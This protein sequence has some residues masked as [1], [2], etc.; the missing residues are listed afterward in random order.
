M[1]SDLGH[2]SNIN[3][4]RVDITQGWGDSPLTH[5]GIEEAEKLSGFLKDK[6]ISIIYSSDLGR[7]VQTSEIINQKLNLK[8]IKSPGL[9]EQNFGKFNNT[10]IIKEEFDASDHSKVPPDGESFLK[11]KQRV[12]TY[13]K[14]KLPRNKDKVLIVTHDGC[15]RAILSDALN[16]DLDSPECATT[17]LTIGLFD[18]KNKDIKFIDKF[19][20]S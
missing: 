9:R 10:S 11:M 1:I 14:T 5:Q 19:N 2:V 4:T 13:I 7:C 20:L 3:G 18:L 12:L 15:F 16:L 17:A 6:E 8:I